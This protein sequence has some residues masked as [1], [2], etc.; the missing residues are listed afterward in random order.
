[1]D[2]WWTRHDFLLTVLLIAS[3][4]ALAIATKIG[5]VW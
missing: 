5:G 1:M 2:R 4:G 3:M